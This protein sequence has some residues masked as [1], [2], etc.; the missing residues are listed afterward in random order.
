[1]SSVY[2]VGKPL[3]EGAAFVYTSRVRMK[4]S[5]KIVA[6]SLLG[7]AYV[8]AAYLAFR[9]NVEEIRAD[10]V[11]I[12][13]SQWQLEGGVR[14][15][16]DAMIKRYEQVNPHVHVVQVAVPGSVYLPWIQTQMVGG[17]GP[18]LAE[19]SWPWP[20]TARNFS[21]ISAEVMEPNPYN[22][23]T[24]LEGVPWRDTFIDGMTSPDNYVQTL[25]QYYGVSTTTGQARIIYNKVLLK[26]ITGSDA[27]PRT[28]REFM[29]M[30]DQI[31]AYAKA[32]ELQ[33]APLANSRTTHITLTNEI[34]A[35]MTVKLAERI[36]FRHRLKIEPEDVGRAYLRGEWG[37]DAPELVAAYTELREVGLVSTPG[38]QQRERDSALTDF[39]S[40]RAVMVVAP[41]WEASSLKELCPFALGAF[42]FPYPRQD[43]PVYGRFTQGP[44][45]EGQVLTG[46]PFYLS[47]QTK[48][49]AEALDFLRFM[50][51]QEGST[52]F[53]NTS[54]WLPIVAGVKPS[55]FSAQFQLQSE[56]YN[57]YGNFFGP[58]SH[59]DPQNY[60]LS[61]LYTLWNTDG[62]VEAFTAALRDGMAGKVRD[63]Y[64]HDVI[65]WRDN[66]RREDA[67]AAA[68]YE[69]AP[70]VR[71]PE[72]LRLITLPNEIGLYQSRA[73]LAKP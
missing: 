57:W 73:V 26:T 58:S 35:N 64:R 63:N 21:P 15:A 39:V 8:T 30:C 69:L 44:F 48:H 7:I 40:L 25:S 27:P 13:I 10:R 42:R 41:S 23:G 1:M 22:R 60:I 34:I 24:P 14:D 3:G 18:D 9:R 37:Y 49:R 45:S 53:T 59:I 43:D 46:M 28:Y 56:G 51:S 72:T 17:T 20:D 38:F 6:F 50:S 54:N 5:G 62:S 68:L 4:F 47:R 29:A 61:I 16:I 2:S 36:D 33:L 71:K 66:A 11:T 55:E 67:A 52:I 70:F 19:Y 65:D 31:R 32:H 12:R